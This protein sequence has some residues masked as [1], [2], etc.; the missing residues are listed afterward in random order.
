M[1]TGLDL[2]HYTD[3]SGFL[4]KSG[5]MEECGIIYDTKILCHSAAARDSVLKK[6]ELVAKY[7]EEE[8]K[9]TFTFWVCK[10]LDD[11]AQ[12]RIFERYENFETMK[13]HQTS[14]TIVDFWMEAKDE[15]KSMEGRCYVPNHKGWLHR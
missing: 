10:S 14:E 4:D 1:T 7:T 9:G 12:I 8:E 6:L 5:N 3:V 15:I 11:D 2:M 13:K